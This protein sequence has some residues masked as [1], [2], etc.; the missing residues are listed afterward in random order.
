MRERV[1]NRAARGGVRSIVAGLYSGRVVPPC[2]YRAQCALDRLRSG[3]P[4]YS[5]LGSA[6]ATW[7][8]RNEAHV[9]RDSPSS[10]LGTP[11]SS[12]GDTGGT[13]PW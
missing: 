10:P 5:N 13:S 6:L 1:D 4:K 2:H 3:S 12:R 8:D 11:L 7:K 9:G